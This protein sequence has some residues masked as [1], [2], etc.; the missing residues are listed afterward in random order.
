MGINNFEDITGLNE[1][2]EFLDKFCEEY[3]IPVCEYKKEYLEI[4]D[5]SHE[6]IMSLTS[7]Q[8][9]SYALLSQ[10]YSIYLKKDLDRLRAQLIWAEDILNRMVGQ[11]WKDFSDYMKYEPK[12][13]AII[14]DDTFATK[15]DKFRQQVSMCILQSENKI[16]NIENISRILEGIA[17]R[18]SYD[19]K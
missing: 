2:L 10:S 14:A 16:Q 11:R 13:Q 9:Y 17:K 4:L 15:L 3:M 8:A 12:R 1:L 7:D 18:R 6:Q 19:N 5:L